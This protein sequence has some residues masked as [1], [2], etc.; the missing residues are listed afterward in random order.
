MKADFGPTAADYAS[1][2]AGFPE[3]L[4]ERLAR[5]GMGRPGQRIADLGSGTGSLARGFARR[6]ARVTAVDISADM[7]AQARTL[8]EGEGVDIE[9]HVAPA[10]ST[11][12]AEG[13]FDAVTAGQ[14]WHWFARPEAAREAWRLLR[15]GGRLAICHFDWIPVP[16]NMVAA[17]E[18]LIRRHNPA[19]DLGGGMGL[20]PAWLA[21]AAAAGFHEIETFSF[22]MAVPYSHEAWRGRVRASA[23]VGGSLAAAAVAR[24]DR[25]LARLLARDFPADPLSIPHRAFA[26]IAR[27]P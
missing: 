22:D 9:T 3:A 1:F 2:R 21:D 23:G 12:L 10:E 16:G 8:A 20:Y 15:P 5:H 11:G 7:L 6:G 13:A 25:D 18:E 26:L 17:T 19:W 14:C 4:F 27:A 24:F